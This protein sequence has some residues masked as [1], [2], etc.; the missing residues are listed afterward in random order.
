MIR[1][2]NRL[3]TVSIS[4][5]FFA[6]LVNNAASDCYGVAG[7]VASGASQGFRQMAGAELADK[8]VLV[9]VKDGALVVELHIE[10][11]YGVNIAVVVRSLVSKVRYAVEDVT[12]FKVEKVNVFVDSMKC[13]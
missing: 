4:N 7:M 10:V 3:G 12:G 2:E 13:E 9:S 5:G 6:E 11:A 1:V 8:G